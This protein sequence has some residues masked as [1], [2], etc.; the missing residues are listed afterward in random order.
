MPPKKH[1]TNMMVFI[2]Y[3]E[4]FYHKIEV[5]Q[6]FL[7]DG[8]NT[9]LLTVVLIILWL[10][11]L[12]RF[13]QFFLSETFI[14]LS[15]TFSSVCFACRVTVSRRDPSILVI[16]TF[17]VWSQS[18]S[19][20]KTSNFCSFYQGFRFCYDHDETATCRIVVCWNVF[21]IFL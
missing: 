14:T 15:Q 4:L 8:F 7:L 9:K 13:H 16:R 1:D 3:W 18:Q 17:S 19:V 12:F 6:L 21:P 11:I 20:K 2:I 5:T 10:L